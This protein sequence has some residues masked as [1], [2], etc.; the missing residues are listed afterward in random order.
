MASILARAPI[1]EG[2]LGKKILFK[3]LFSPPGFVWEL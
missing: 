3:K 2:A 1:L